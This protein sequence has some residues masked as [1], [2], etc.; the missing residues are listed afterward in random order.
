[1]KTAQTG[2]GKLISKGLF[3]FFNSPKK[4]TKNFCPSRL[5]QKLT[6]LSFFFGGIGDTKTSFRD[7]LTFTN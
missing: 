1:M 2:K 3:G 6:F 7:E 5:G 4:P